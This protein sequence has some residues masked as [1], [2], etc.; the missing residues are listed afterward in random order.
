MDVSTLIAREL[1]DYERYLDQTEP[2]YIDY[3]EPYRLTFP[4]WKEREDPCDPDVDA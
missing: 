2:G 4:K 3:Y 1:R